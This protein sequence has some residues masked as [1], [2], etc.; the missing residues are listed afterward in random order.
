MMSP[1]TRLYRD[2]AK[3]EAKK[4]VTATAEAKP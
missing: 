1:T 3:V 4:P 2:V